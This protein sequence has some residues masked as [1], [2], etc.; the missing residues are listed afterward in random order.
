[1]G[2][3]RYL[4]FCGTI[5]DR[6]E[7]RK[8]SSKIKKITEHLKTLEANSEVDGCALV[9]DRGQLMASALHKDMDEKAISAMA[10]ALVS[11]G[12][13]VGTSL[14]SGAPKNIVIEG[15]GKIVIVRSIGKASM[16][17]T[18]PSEAKIGLIDFEMDK[19]SEE[20]LAVL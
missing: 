1:M 14:G 19:V 10:A 11:I 15:S 17:A 12:G 16:I 4:L 13:R 8:M 5:R 18:A 20:V 3:L 6:H 9:S 2:C 7:L